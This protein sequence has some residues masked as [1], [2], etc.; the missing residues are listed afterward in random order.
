MRGILQQPVSLTNGLTDQSEFAIFEIANTAMH[1]VRG[2]GTC[3][4][5]VIPAVDEEHIHALQ[6]QVEEGPN[7]VN[8]RA[9]DQDADTGVSCNQL[10]FFPFEF[11][12]FPYSTQSKVRVT[13][14]FHCA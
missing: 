4:A 3:P 5:A 7:P 14:F 9:N 2:R 12:C 1:H 13:A 8:P 11:A 6:R 10:E